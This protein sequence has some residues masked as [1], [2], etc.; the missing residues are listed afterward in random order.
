M[1]KIISDYGYCFGVNNAIEILKRASISH[2]HVY[3]T[4]PLIHNEKANAELMKET[5][6]EMLPASFP[7][8]SAVVFS[9]HGHTLEEE[10][11]YKRRAELIDA[12]CPLIKK[13]YEIIKTHD[14]SEKTLLFL[15]KPHHQET[16][17]FLSH[18]PQLILL[19]A[20][21]DL[22]QQISS[23]KLLP[24]TFLIPQTTIS[25]DKLKEAVGLLKDKTE[26]SYLNICSLYQRRY[27]QCI[28]FLK[29]TDISKSFLIVV[30][31][32]SS[33]NTQEIYKAIKKAYPHLLMKIGQ[34]LDDLD[35]KEL[36]DKDIYLTSATSASK[37]T[38]EKLKED[39][40]SYFEY[41]A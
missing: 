8:G 41:S 23:L 31:D 30:G 37:K 22:A 21:A 16:L 15:G 27:Q 1:I 11:Q 9:A 33:S 19:D 38:V 10:E 4:H 24:K 36:K 32:T 40:T 6:S 2:K 25:E 18:F 12:T 34:T 7:E 13:N 14:N 28:E 5:N 17:G 39:L 26:L 3:L 29:S 20:T 35:L